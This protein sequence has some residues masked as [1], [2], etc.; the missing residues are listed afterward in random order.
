VQEYELLFEM[1]LKERMGNCDDF[2]WLRRSSPSP[3]ASE[4]KAAIVV[5]RQCEPFLAPL[6]D[7]KYKN[8]MQ[9]RGTSNTKTAV[10]SLGTTG[11]KG[12]IKPCKIRHGARLPY[13]YAVI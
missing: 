9:E 13:K 8:E 12:P 7:R 6:D 10:K 2:K 4:S 1:V 11:C 5:G 3:P